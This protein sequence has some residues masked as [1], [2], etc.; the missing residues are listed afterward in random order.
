MRV[1]SRQVVQVAIGNRT[2]ITFLLLNFIPMII[3]IMLC[4]LVFVANECD[5]IEVRERAPDRAST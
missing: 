4:M 5:T 1:V 3:A 2:R